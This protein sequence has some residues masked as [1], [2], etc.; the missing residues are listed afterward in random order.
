[1]PRGGQVAFSC[2]QS[3]SL[4]PEAAVGR[5]ATHSHFSAGVTG[6]GRRHRIFGEKCGI[7]AAG[8]CQ[9]KLI[10]TFIKERDNAQSAFCYFMDKGKNIETKMEFE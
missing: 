8:D 10:R 5:G 9:P 6:F 3:E 4:L 7:L 1:V 2:E